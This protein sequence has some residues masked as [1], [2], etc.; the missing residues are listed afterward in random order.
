[1][2]FCIADEP[3][4]AKLGSSYF[5]LFSLFDSEFERKKQRALATNLYKKLTSRMEQLIN[6]EEKTDYV[7]QI[8]Q[9]MK[10]ELVEDVDLKRADHLLNC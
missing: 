7:I 5:K 10:K 1:M 4:K 9:K 8:L 3:R 6:R 2:C